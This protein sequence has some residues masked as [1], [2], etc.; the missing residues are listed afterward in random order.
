MKVT[1]QAGAFFEKA[2]TISVVDLTELASIVIGDGTSQRSEVRQVTL[3]FDGPVDLSSGAFTL[4]QRGSNQ[5]VTTTATQTALGNGQ[6]Q[7]VL[8]FSGA[9]TRNGSLV[10]G[11]YQL[12][13]DGTKI[14]RAGQMLDANSDGVSGDQVVLGA[15]ESDNFFAIYG[16]TNGDGV[17]G[18]AEF[19]Q[20]R[21]SFGKT[22]ADPG[23]NAMFDYDRDGA[24]G[25]SDFG[26]FR[27][28][29][30]KP[31]PPF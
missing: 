6:S 28:R 25:V 26:Q 9:L 4:I 21:A 30:G 13:V 16:D 5:A 8:T 1:D 19:G 20:F 11:Y 15:V 2:L 27:S 3:R 18:I 31:K 12:T 22:Q 23:Y 29:F 14:L 17:V 7:V 10:D 24:V